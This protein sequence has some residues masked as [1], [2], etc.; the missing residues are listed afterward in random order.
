LDLKGSVEIT[1]WV[2]EERAHEL[3]SAA[4]VCVNLRGPTTGG[5]SGGANQAF[6]VGRGVIISELP[7]LAELPRAAA[8]RVRSGDGEAAALS[9]LFVSL[10]SD[11]SKISA[12]EQAAR[13]YVEESAHWGHV[14]AACVEALEH[15]PA[16]RASRRGVIQSAVRQRLAGRAQR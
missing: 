12:M 10:S 14:A 7:E 2:D 16:P 15:F 6:S 9:E 8:L 3:L 13:S 1:G 5:A 4:D 11:R